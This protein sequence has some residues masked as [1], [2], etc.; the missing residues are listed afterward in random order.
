LSDET[1]F[2]TRLAG[3]GMQTGK[4]RLSIFTSLRF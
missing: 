3:G 1:G 2:N 4:T